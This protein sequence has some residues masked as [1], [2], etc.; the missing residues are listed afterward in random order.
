MQYKTKS[1]K[2]LGQNFLQDE[3]IIRQ[4]VQLANIKKHEIVV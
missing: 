1:K 4:S 2:S 3:N